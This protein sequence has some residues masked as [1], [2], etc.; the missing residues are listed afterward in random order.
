[1]YLSSRLHGSSSLFTVEYTSFVLWILEGNPQ[2]TTTMQTFG[3]ALGCWDFSQLRVWGLFQ[4]D[5]AASAV[6]PWDSGVLG[7]MH[8]SPVSIFCRV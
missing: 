6:F 4:G 3:R 5:A 7:A 8:V 1:M 2:K